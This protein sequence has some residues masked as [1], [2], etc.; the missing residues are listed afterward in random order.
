[1]TV[2]EE[3]ETRGTTTVADR[4]VQR[5]ATRLVTEMEGVGGSSRRMLG[6]TVGGSEPKIDARV[7]GEQVTLDVELSVAYPASVPKTTEAARE[8][9]TREVAELTGLIVD[10]VDITVTSLRGADSGERRVR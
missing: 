4:A 9:L 3:I 6:L 7:R 8:Q 5:I 2:T 1:M 10:R